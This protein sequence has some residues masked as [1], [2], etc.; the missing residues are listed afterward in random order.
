MEGNTHT[1]WAPRPTDQRTTG[2]AGIFAAKWGEPLPTNRAA[3]I[4]F[5]QLEAGAV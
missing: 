2:L 5:G 3:A 4:A 1:V